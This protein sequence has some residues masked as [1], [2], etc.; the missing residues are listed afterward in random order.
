M[1]LRPVPRAVPNTYAESNNWKIIQANDRA[2]A[3]PNAT[4]LEGDC[5]GHVVM[6]TAIENVPP[7]D[8][9]VAIPQTGGFRIK[10]SGG[11][12]ASVT[13]QTDHGLMIRAYLA[14]RGIYAGPG[15]TIFDTVH[16]NAGVDYL[17]A[18]GGL[19]Q[20]YELSVFLPDAAP[21]PHSQFYIAHSFPAP[22]DIRWFVFGTDVV[23]GP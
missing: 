4:M 3:L 13:F 20:L 17:T 5:H 8:T 10:T 7:S 15:R 21:G 6:L 9:G 19:G 14:K 23:I 11:A 16:P 18:P 12:T 2:L 22:Q 1:P